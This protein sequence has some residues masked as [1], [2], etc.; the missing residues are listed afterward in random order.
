MELAGSPMVLAKKSR[1]YPAVVDCHKLVV[2]VGLLGMLTMIHVAQIVLFPLE[3][4]NSEAVESECAPDV[5]IEHSSTQIEP[6]V[7]LAGLSKL[8]LLLRE[9]THLE[10]DMGFFHEVA[11][12]DASL[13]LHD[14]ILS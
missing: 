11:L 2:V 13:G 5:I 7:V 10:V 3:E 8:T 9:L 12:L 14:Q 1:A 6:L 4:D